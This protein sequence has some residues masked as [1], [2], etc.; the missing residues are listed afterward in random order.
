MTKLAFTHSL[1]RLFINRQVLIG[2]TLTSFVLLLAIAGPW[3]SPYLPQDLTGVRYGHPNADAILGY[4]YLGH[5]VLSR[6]LYG[7]R[8]IVWMALASSLIA[9]VIGATLG[10]IAGFFRRKIDHFIIWWADIFLAFPNLILVLLIVSMLG[11]DKWLI[12]ITVAIAFIPG[13]VRLTRS[14][15][16]GIA[17]QEYIE[18]TEMMA[19]PYHQILLKEILPNITT[20][21]LIHLGT[22]L[23]WAVAILSGL[24]FLGYGVAPPE[25]DWGL[26]VNENRG[27]LQIQPYAVLVPIVLIA[28]FALGTNLLAEGLGRNKARIAERK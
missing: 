19:Y 21:L 22:M 27:G 2:F 3:F 28:F 23:S 26:M 25:A 13:V 10:L 17:Q 5:D 15:S 20:P 1:R 8:S 6:V 4:D 12:V 11:R 14:V 7:G 9:L 16:L 18:A 24:S